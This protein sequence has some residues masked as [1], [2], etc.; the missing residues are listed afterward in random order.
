MTKI[1]ILILIIILSVS[2]TSKSDI[3]QETDLPAKDSV[4]TGLRVGRKA[5][6]LAFK[7]PDGKI[8]KLSSLRGKMVLIDFWASWCPPCRQDNPRLVGLYHEFKD[9][10]FKEGNGFTIYSV[11]LDKKKD[12]WIKAIKKDSLEWKSHVSDLG[13]WES[14]PAKIYKVYSI[15]VNFLINE[16]GI[17]VAR[18]LN[19]DGL[20]RKLRK[21]NRKK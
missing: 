14:E 11:S 10:K 1:Y 21:L 5:P 9:N 13:G 7:S 18:Y 16:D 15:P 6:E 4:K 20:E 3:I 19:L 17:I 2:F 8:I 12:D